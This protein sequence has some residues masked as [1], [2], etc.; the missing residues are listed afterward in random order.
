MKRWMLL[1]LIVAPLLFGQMCG[2]PAEQ[3]DPQ[4]QE[5]QNPPSNDD[6]LPNPPTPTLVCGGSYRDTSYGFGFNPLPSSGQPTLYTDQAGELRIDWVATVDSR[7]DYSLRVYP[8]IET[9][10]TLRAYGLSQL[11]AGEVLIDD[12]FIPMPSGLVAWYCVK[13]TNSGNYVARIETVSRMK[14]FG[15]SAV[16]SPTASNYT[17]VGWM[18]LSFCVDP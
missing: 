10:E 14:Y 5:D 15:L 9:P 12:R 2:A 16:Y 18:L 4:A 1:I 17:D 8:A 6:A 7:I 11:G 3:P 13:Q